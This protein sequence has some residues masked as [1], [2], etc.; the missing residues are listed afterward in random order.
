[1]DSKFKKLNYDFYQIRSHYLEI[2]ESVDKIENEKMF[3]E[4][5]W[6]PLRYFISQTNISFGYKIT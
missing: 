2:C 1:M 4:K 3:S 5:D 6:G